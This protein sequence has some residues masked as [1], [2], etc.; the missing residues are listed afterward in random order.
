[1][2]VIGAD[3]HPLGLITDGDLLRRSRPTPQAGLIDRVRRLLSGTADTMAVLPAVDE[4]ARDLMTTPV[5]VIAITGSLQEAIRLM[6]QHAIKRLPVV[7]ESEQLVGLLDRASVLRG[8]AALI[9]GPSP[10]LG[11]GS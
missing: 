9:P 4:T 8:L 1:M 5:V 3:N 11:E 10:S 2:V 6:T 7:D